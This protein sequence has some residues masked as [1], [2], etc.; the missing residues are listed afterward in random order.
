MSSKLGLVLSL[1][2]ASTA[3]VLAQQSCGSVPFEPAMPSPA[4]MKTKSVP[5]AETALHDAVSDIKNWQAD[6]KTYRACLDA[7]GAQAKAGL[8]GLDKD[9][10]ADKIKDLKEVK[11]SSD[12]LYDK[13]VDRE[14]AVVNEFH[15][16]QASY[17]G[18][19][20]ANK[21]KCPK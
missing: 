12:H 17:C 9:K 2:L 8:T 1:F 6:L 19:P 11:A 5:D 16:A 18:R 3:P 21:N 14:E 4:D 13:S 20:D 10:D 15:L 7:Q